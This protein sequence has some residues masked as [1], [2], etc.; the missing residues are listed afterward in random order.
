M[1][2]CTTV[3]LSIVVSLVCVVVC[4]CA[5]VSETPARQSSGG[6]GG[7]ETIGCSARDARIP[8]RSRLIL[9]RPTAGRNGPNI[10]PALRKQ[11]GPA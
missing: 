2:L 6:G 9:H 4:V 7:G 5:C 1:L 11:T 8:A 3:A 10:H